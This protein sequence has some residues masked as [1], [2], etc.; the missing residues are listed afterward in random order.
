MFIMTVLFLANLKGLGLY[1]K[2]EGKEYRMDKIKQL[3]NEYKT[4]YDYYEAV[5]KLASR[6]LEAL[7]EGSA[8]RAIVTFRTKSA[9]SLERKLRQRSLKRREPYLTISDVYDDIV[10]LSGVRIALYFPGDKDKVDSIITNNFHLSERVRSFPDPKKPQPA[11]SRFAGYSANHYRVQMRENTLSAKQ[12]KYAD[13]KI[14]IQVASVLMHAW[15]EVEHDLIYKPLSG[16]LTKEELAILDE[17]NGLVLTGEIALERLQAAEDMRINLSK[18]NFK[19]QFDLASFLNT[20]LQRR[21]KPELSILQMGNV[22]ILYKLLKQ[23][24]LDN[25]A[26]LSPYLRS[27][28]ISDK[29]LKNNETISRQIIDQILLGHHERYL[30]FKELL[31]SDSESEFFSNQEVGYFLR[32]WI[33][34]ETI[35]SALTKS[36]NPKARNP[37]TP[38]NLQKLNLS[39]GQISKIFE[40]KKIRNALVHENKIPEPDKLSNHSHAIKELK[41][42][43]EVQN[44]RT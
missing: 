22:E 3:V 21:D 15:S 12:K 32:Q 35:V 30:I 2:K 40:L 18:D 4:Q 1:L 8:V 24:Q 11:S 29:A 27:I 28:R 38:F 9:R 26:N 43:I 5:G 33:A 41:Q 37:F 6:K 19:S 7:L 44:K 42:E 13:A 23:L 20:K 16:S 14:E 34:L 31:A 10:D 36:E 25:G 39:K 17:L